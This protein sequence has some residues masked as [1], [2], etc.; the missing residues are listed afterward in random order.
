MLRSRQFAHSLYDYRAF[1]RAGYTRAASVE[2]ICQI[3]DLRLARR[4]CYHGNTVCRCSRDHNIFRCTDARKRKIYFCTVKPAVCTAFYE[5]VFGQNL[6]A[7]L[8]DTVKMNI[9]RAK[10]YLTTAGRRKRHFSRA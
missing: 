8:F 2:K 10:P 9:Y 7:E 4:V 5:S 3:A 1:S 6:R